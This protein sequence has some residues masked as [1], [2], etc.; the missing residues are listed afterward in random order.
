MAAGTTGYTQDFISKKEESMTNSLLYDLVSQVY[1]YAQ[2]NEEA[3]KDQ[4]FEAE[5]KVIEELAQKGNCVI[6]GRCSDYILR[7]RTDCL[8][9]Y[10]SAPIEG[11]VKR[12]MKRLN[13]SEKE[14][15][16]RIQR[17]DKRRADNYRYYTGRIWGVA[18]NFDITL[19]TE[20]G[21]EYIE[22]CVCEALNR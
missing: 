1:M 5:K 14:A 8:K 4:I 3:P 15:K 21:M 19:N 20:L 7:N 10:F 12:V 2:T 13:L 18:A 16:Q 22:N 17:E 9:I 11:R 6:V